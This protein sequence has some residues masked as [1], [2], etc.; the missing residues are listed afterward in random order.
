MSRH[1]C[2][3]DIV[4]EDEAILVI[5]K[6]AGLLVIPDRWD[7]GK[8]TVVELAQ[9][10]L[11][12]RGD[13]AVGGSAPQRL[14]CSAAKPPPLPTPTR[15]ATSATIDIEREIGGCAALRGH[16]SPAQ[17]A[18]GGVGVSRAAR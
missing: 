8:P 11:Q 10:H 17:Y 6:P 3:L 1:T 9:A 16:V 12:A 7:P 18:R 14:C 4:Y 5:N 15:G 13:L 2:N